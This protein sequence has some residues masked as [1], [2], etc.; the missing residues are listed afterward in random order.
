[1]TLDNIVLQ[2]ELKYLENNG[3]LNY[4]L[5]QSEELEIEGEFGKTNFR[6]LDS[7]YKNLREYVE[8]LEL[9]DQFYGEEAETLAP[10]T[11]ISIVKDDE[12][13]DIV[14]C[15]DYKPKLNEMET[16]LKLKQLVRNVNHIAEKF[17]TNK[18]SREI[19]TKVIKYL[20]KESYE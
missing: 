6:L 8:K 16:F 14:L 19:I 18:K 1:M 7:D 13:K 11:G 5:Y 15:W 17:I 12:Q 3:F 9:S 20:K 4:S 10:I 2:I